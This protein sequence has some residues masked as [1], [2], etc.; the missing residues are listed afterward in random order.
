MDSLTNKT[1]Q[2]TKLIL[3]LSV[4]ALFLSCKEE[5]PTIQ[6]S[7]DDLSGNY[8]NSAIPT[9][10]KVV[11]LDSVYAVV[12]SS[13]AFDTTNT[14]SRTDFFNQQ[15]SYISITGDTIAA[16]TGVLYVKDIQS[17]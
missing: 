11:I 7:P 9:Y 10:D 8:Y 13:G 17:W 2:M 16:N 15:I 14:W 6:A 1:R 3:S 5:E 4:M 12:Y